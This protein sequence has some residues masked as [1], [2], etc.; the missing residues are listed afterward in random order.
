LREGS[1][2]Q[3]AKGCQPQIWADKKI[4]RELTRKTRI[5]NLI[6]VVREIRG[7]LFSGFIDRV[8]FERQAQGPP[9]YSRADKSARSLNGQSG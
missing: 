6:R 1:G 9:S 3:L 2:Q 4:S 5:M 7:H 8:N